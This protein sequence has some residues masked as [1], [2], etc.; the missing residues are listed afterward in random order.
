MKN[1]KRAFTIV[2][3]VIVIAVI[4]ILAAVLIPTFSGLIEKAN[5]NSDQA[6]V[7]QMNTYL[8]SDE[9]INGKCSGWE[10]AV[11]VLNK[12]NL[13]A[14]NYMALADGYQIVY[15]KDINRVLYVKG[16][17][18]IY[19]EEYKDVSKWLKNA[20]E[21]AWVYLS[22]KYVPDDSW[23]STTYTNL[24]KYEATTNSSGE[25]IY[26]SGEKEYKESEL[27]DL[28]YVD[29]TSPKDVNLAAM[30][31]KNNTSI[32]S[33]SAEFVG[34]DGK[35]YK[36]SKLANAAE[37]VDY[38]G[39]INKMSK[40]EVLKETKNETLIISKDMD[41]GKTEWAPI[42][43]F[44]GNVDGSHVNPETGIKENSKI[45]NLNL[46]AGVAQ[47]E[48]YQGSGESKNFYYGFISIFRGE[49]LGNLTFTA[50]DVEKPGYDQIA[51]N[52]KTTPRG[53]QFAAVVC[54]LIRPISGTESE[55]TQVLIEN[56]EV[57]G[58][59]IISA[60]RASSLF[61]AI[62]EPTKKDSSYSPYGYYD[63][64]I[65]KCIN[66]ANVTSLV[67]NDGVTSASYGTASAFV[68][69]V[70]SYSAYGKV[71]FEECENYGNVTGMY[72]AGFIAMTNNNYDPKSD[73]F[74]SKAQNTGTVK[75]VK[76]ANHGTITAKVDSSFA[77]RS[78]G[79]NP[80]AAGF[81]N[82]QTNTMDLISFDGCTSDGKIVIEQV[83]NVKETKNYY[84]G[85]FTADEKIQNGSQTVEFVS[86]CNY[87][88]VKYI[89]SIDKADKVY[90]ADGEDYVE[91]TKDYT[92][93][94][95]ELKGNYFN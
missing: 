48:V 51:Q 7:K 13:D 16:S 84:A 15:A 70:F 65:R 42:N 46:N 63:I 3:L 90:I 77:E 9:Q 33:G 85:A 50:H 94:K 37:L 78:T 60:T 67:D 75:F 36:F 35:T 44:A 89:I 82:V 24:P 6:A 74:D 87:E 12:S 93:S 31:F 5:V 43:T 25:T 1:S 40:E 86:K 14:Q 26:K 34:S 56:I 21:V 92:N 83:G 55:R 29:Y 8:A 11:K 45:E 47:I 4:A 22:G 17:E 58:G 91:V 72:A 76:C 73:K 57:E 81:I 69:K 52:L 62:G 41:L 38:N 2:E 18:V 68:N 71:T 20:N 32:K 64:T 23:R 10:D 27:A 88:N 95:V 79:G 19:P 66:R 39:Q 61:G 28:A 49:Y 30:E 59:E 53:G 80:R 54:G